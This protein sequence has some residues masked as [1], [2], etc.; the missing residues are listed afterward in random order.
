MKAKIFLSILLSAITTLGCSSPFENVPFNVPPNPSLDQATLL[1]IGKWDWDKSVSNSTGP[2]IEYTPV[3][4]GY[5]RQLR[6]FEDGTLQF[7]KNDSLTKTSTFKV[8]SGYYS[9][10]L[11]LIMDG[12]V[13]YD[14]RITENEFSYDNRPADGSAGYYI[15]QQ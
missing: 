3:S 5:T 9:P 7:F 15:R 4:V 14:F 1:I 6:F 8:D 12:F 10:G 11:T 2:T 13:H